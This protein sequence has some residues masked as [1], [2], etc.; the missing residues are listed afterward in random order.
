MRIALTCLDFSER[1]AQ[2]SQSLDSHGGVLIW[3][4]GSTSVGRRRFGAS[5]IAA[6]GAA[7]AAL[8]VCLTSGLAL[9]A[10]GPTVKTDPPRCVHPG[11]NASVGA[12]ITPSSASAPVASARVRFHAY[13]HEG[14]YYLEMRR[15]DHDQYWA[16]LPQVKES[17]DAILYRVVAKDV[18]GQESSS[19]SLMI[20]TGMDCPVPVLNPDE[21]RYASNLVLGLTSDGQADTPPG[22]LCT[23][24]ISVIKTSGQLASTTCRSGVPTAVWVGVAAGTALAGGIVIA[25]HA[26]GGGG[27]PVSTARPAKP[28]TAP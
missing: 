24:I 5:G 26:G 4:S 14:D 10:S 20:H 9:G 17:T 6:V 11:S 7:R 3:V 13:G 12:L 2:I 8:V 21:R 22:F 25:N 18:A 27:G 1:E 23:G 19:A 16:V 28:A 15:G